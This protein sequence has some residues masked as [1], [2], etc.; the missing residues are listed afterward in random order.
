MTF[1]EEKN[2]KGCKEQGHLKFI[3]FVEQGEEFSIDN[4]DYYEN[5]K[6]ADN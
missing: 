3:V 2:N 4:E 6:I 5:R 1:S